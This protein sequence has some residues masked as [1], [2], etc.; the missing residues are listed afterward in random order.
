MCRAARTA[1][2]PSRQP[3][4]QFQAQC[5]NLSGRDDKRTMPNLGRNVMAKSPSLRCSELPATYPRHGDPHTRG[6][7]CSKLPQLATLININATCDPTIIVGRALA[8]RSRGDAVPVYVRGPGSSSPPPDPAS[9]GGLWYPSLTTAFFARRRIDFAAGSHWL[10]YHG[11][12][13][14]IASRTFLLSRNCG[15]PFHLNLSGR[16]SWRPLSC[17]ALASCSPQWNNLCAG[18]YVHFL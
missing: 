4:N 11:I 3:Q 1:R 12:A 18:P 2:L 15:R 8:E 6:F 17:L 9:V 7:L 5:P 10:H 14:A 13:G 16:L